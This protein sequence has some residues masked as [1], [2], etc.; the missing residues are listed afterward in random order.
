[1]SL[2]LDYNRSSD[3]TTGLDFGTR[4]GTINFRQPQYL[5]SN[6]KKLF[7]V[8]RVMLSPEMPN[9]YNTGGINTTTVNL[10]RDGGATWITCLLKTGIYTT[11]M[12]SD[13]INNVAELQGWWAVAGDYGFD[14]NYNPATKMVYIKLDS[15]KLVAPGTQLAIDFGVSQMGLMLGFSNTN[16]SFNTDGVHTADLSPQ[17][18]WQGQYIEVFCSVIQGVR[19]VNGQLSSALCRVPIS[20]STSEIVWPSANTGMI[21]PLV[22]ASIPNV[23]QSFDIT[24]RNAKGNDAVFLYG[25]V[26]VEIEIVDA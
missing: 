15:T 4:N 2:L 11:T 9:V 13:S 24:I 23:I 25:G 22:P 14:L 17:L 21:S 5:D 19:W 7:R 26:S 1:M 16:D 18:D 3:S 12:I 6:K 10:S 8:L 20:A